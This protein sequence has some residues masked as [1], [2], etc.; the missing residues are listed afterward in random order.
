MCCI[1][2]TPDQ[3]RACGCILGLLIVLYGWGN[4]GLDTL[5]G[6]G[7]EGNSGSGGVYLLLVLVGA[8][9]FFLKI[10]ACGIEY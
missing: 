7:R 5:G 2:S 3:T 6:G 9:C 4:M 8:V 10:T 1:V